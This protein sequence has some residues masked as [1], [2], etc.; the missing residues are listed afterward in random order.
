MTDAEI[1]A[2]I[3]ERTTKEL[4]SFREKLKRM[5]TP[6]SWS[7]RFHIIQELLYRHLMGDEEAA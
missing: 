2:K 5:N 6:E 7:L 3:A 1:R 4:L